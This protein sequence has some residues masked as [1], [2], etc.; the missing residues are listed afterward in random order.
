MVC[1]NRGKDGVGEVV[2][3]MVVMMEW[4]MVNVVTAAHA[5]EVRWWCVLVRIWWWEGAIGRCH[6]RWQSAISRHVVGAVWWRRH[7]RCSGGGFNCG[8]AGGHLRGEEP[9]LALDFGKGGGDRCQL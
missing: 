8:N 1:G 5:V 9:Q 4:V 7:A 3:G 2:C 6:G